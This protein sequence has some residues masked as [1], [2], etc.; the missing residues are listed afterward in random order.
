MAYWLVK[1]E[2]TK[3]TFEMFLKDGNTCW[4]GVRNYQ[5][6]NNLRLMKMGDDVVFYHSGKLKSAM[7]TA[8]VISEGYPDPTAEEGD[9]TA[10]DL[11]VQIEFAEPVALA[12][13]RADK[14]LAESA[15]VKQTRLSVMPLNKSQFE[16]FKKLGGQ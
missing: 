15:L 13:V 12:T 5:A 4:D 6:R 10:V 14:V 8:K 3:Y 16:N 7:G 9:W 11:E 1:E 2:P